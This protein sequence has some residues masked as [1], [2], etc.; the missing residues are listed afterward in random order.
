MLKL[1]LSVLL[2]SGIHTYFFPIVVRLFRSYPWERFPFFSFPSLLNPPQYIFSPS[3]SFKCFV[4]AIKCFV[5]CSK[6]SSVLFR[7]FN[8]KQRS[9][10]GAIHSLLLET[11]SFGFQDTTVFWF[12]SIT[13]AAPFQNSLLG[14]L[15][16]LS[17]KYWC[18]QDLFG[19]ISLC[20]YIHSRL[21]VLNAINVFTFPNAYLKPRQLALILFF[22]YYFFNLLFPLYNMGTK[23]H[24]HV[25]IFFPPFVLL[26]YKYLD[27]VL[28]A[29]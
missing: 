29:I 13:P 28:N 7:H 4:K 20:C 11:L 19:S 3:T 1:L 15:R 17:S 22:Y 6:S 16:C 10:E 18:V 2:H 24:L 12:P 21:L 23:L 14:S 5:K 8:S 27:I 26:Q 25:Y 9:F